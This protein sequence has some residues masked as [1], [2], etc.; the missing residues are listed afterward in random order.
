MNIEIIRDIRNWHAG[1]SILHQSTETVRRYKPKEMAD[2]FGIRESAIIHAG[3]MQLESFVVAL[4]SSWM[5]DGHRFFMQTSGNTT[6]FFMDEV[7]SL[8]VERLRFLFTTD[9]DTSLGY[10]QSANR[11]T[12]SSKRDPSKVVDVPGST[13]IAISVEPSNWGSFLT[14]ILPKAVMLKIMGFERL[15]VYAPHPNQKLLLE[16]AGWKPEEIILQET[17]RQYRF[18]HAVWPSEPTI[19]LGLGLMG[20]CALQSLRPATLRRDR[21]LYVTR[22]AGQSTRNKRYA[23]NTEQIERALSSLGFEIVRPELLTPLEQAQLFAEARMVVGPSGAGMFNT[24]FCAP[25][26]KVI[27][28]ESEPNWLFG[29]CNLFSS[30]RL[31]YSIHWARPTS[32]PQFPPPHRPF[33]VDIPCLLRQIETK[34]GQSANLTAMPT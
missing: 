12:Y 5:L 7:V 8:P 23:A 15:F 16:A 19:H 28:I 20:R 14:R 3:D 34:L 21:L 10:D 27:D 1:T 24:V 26:T 18:E 6:R 2:P 31:D 30:S 4:D 11:F 33:D 25:G 32:D 29:H 13:G 17:Y 22:H 9:L